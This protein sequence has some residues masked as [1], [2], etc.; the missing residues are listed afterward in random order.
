MPPQK[1][2]KPVTEQ[3]V[4]TVGAVMVRALEV[5]EMRAPKLSGSGTTEINW[6]GDE[7]GPCLLGAQSLVGKTES[8]LV[9]VL[10]TCYSGCL[11]QMCV[12]PRGRCE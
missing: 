11:N 9:L 2:H 5:G 10:S 8:Y 6:I 7:Q 12:V 1:T 4:A 3:S